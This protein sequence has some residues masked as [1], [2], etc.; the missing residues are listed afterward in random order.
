MKLKLINCLLLLTI[1]SA[2]GRFYEKEYVYIPPSS[3]DG[4]KCILQ[5][6]DRQQNC[7]NIANKAYQE[8]LRNME[9]V[10]MIKYNIDLNSQQISKTSNER[11]ITEQCHNQINQEACQQ[12]YNDCYVNK[13]GGQIEAN[14]FSSVSVN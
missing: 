3:E 2:C 13:C 1:S 6:R 14:R 12:G 5:C 10:S 11:N 8:C 7:E 4:R 9:Q